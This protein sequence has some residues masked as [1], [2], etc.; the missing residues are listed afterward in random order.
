VNVAPGGPK[1]GLESNAEVIEKLAAP[2]FP[3]VAPAPGNMRYPNGVGG[4]SAIVTVE[5][6][7]P[8]KSVVPNVGTA[9]PMPFW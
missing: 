8:V 5:P 9:E 3:L 4:S 1:S 7:D 2:I 6:K